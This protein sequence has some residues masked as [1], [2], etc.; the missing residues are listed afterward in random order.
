MT[1]KWYYTSP[2]TSEWTTTITSAKKDGDTYIITL[3]ETAFYPEGGGQPCD[4]GVIAGIPVLEVF[5][6]NEEV[7]HRLPSLPAASTVRCQIDM[8]RRLDH[9]QQ[10]SGQHL[11]SAVC[12]ELFDAHTVGFHMGSEV[13]TIDL[14]V[15]SLSE[16]A[17]TA[18]E[19]RANELIYAN[20]PVETY[21]VTKEEARQ[22]P[23]RKLPKIEGNI[24]VVEIKGIDV[25]ACCGT[26]VSRTG[27]IGMIK[28]LKAERHRGMTRLSFVC[29]KRALT[30]YQLSHRIAT[31]VSQQLGTN[32]DM[33]LD[34]LGKWEAEKKELQK[35]LEQYKEILFAIEAENAAQQA[36]QEQVV[37]RVYKQY[38][39]K[40]IQ[41]IANMI[42]NR[43]EKTAVLATALEQRIVIVKAP[44]LSLHIGKWLKEM[45]S[46]SSGKGGGN[47][48][49]AQAVFPS[50]EEMQKFLRLLQD[51]IKK[52]SACD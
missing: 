11:L 45:L 21:Y 4:N 9:T 35:Q 30:D 7:Y 37:M 20:I 17:L 25:S 49:Q 47:E 36:K 41:T 51:D 24:R 40:D 1:E 13:V 5:E 34:V 6:K 50:E 44:S 18:I 43:Y 48:R 19:N 33:L 46:L 29:G 10:H 14:N 31:A 27:E 32:R 8:A 39:L 38:T 23:F 52:V 42:A 3:S 22:L 2:T 28:L 16:E 26:H 15:P 12:I